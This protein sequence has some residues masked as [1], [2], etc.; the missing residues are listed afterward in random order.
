MPL[1]G[2]MVLNRSII[3]PHPCAAGNRDSVMKTVETRSVRTNMPPG[4]RA[5]HIEAVQD[6][7]VAA[8]QTWALLIPLHRRFLLCNQELFPWFSSW[9]NNYNGGSGDKW[10]EIKRGCAVENHWNQSWALKQVTHHKFSYVN[11]GSLKFNLDI[12]LSNLPLPPDN[13]LTMAPSAHQLP[14]REEICPFQTWELTV[15]RLTRSRSSH[16]NS[17]HPMSSASTAKSAGSG[18]CYMNIN[19]S[20]WWSA[21][22]GRRGPRRDEEVVVGGE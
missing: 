14:L 2:W 19:S 8:V 17:Y 16:C 7:H 10:D 13:Q 5:A 15:N 20:C 21:R 11:S 18:R 3:H 1:I 22:E 9:L 6:E 4:V 12:W